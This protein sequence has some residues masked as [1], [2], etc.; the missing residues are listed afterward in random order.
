MT[1]ICHIDCE[2]KSGVDITN[3]VD[4]YVRDPDYG[5]LIGTYAFDDGPVRIWEPWDGEPI[6]ADL[7]EAARDPA[8]LFS[9]HNARFERLTIN[10]ELSIPL[11]R[12]RCTMA[13]AYSHALPGAL[14]SLCR[15]LGLDDDK[16]KK[17]DGK[18][19]I[20][21][22]CTP[23]FADPREHPAD[24][25]DFLDYAAQDV[26]AMRECRRRMPNVNY[27]K[28]QSELEA[29][30]L[31]QRINDRGF[32]VDV[33]MAKVAMCRLAVEKETLN[34][35]ISDVSGGLITKGTQGERIKDYLNMI[36]GIAVPDMQK[37]TLE[38]LLDSG[39]VTGDA[40]TLLNIRRDLSR[41]STSKYER[42][43]NSQV[44]G[45]IH[46]AAQFCGAGRTGRW[47]GRIFQPLNLPRP[48]LKAD[49]VLAEVEAL[50]RN[51]PP[52]LYGSEHDRCADGLRSAIVAGPG[53]KLVVADWSS[54][55][56][57]LNAWL[58]K[59]QWVLD[60][61]AAGR[62]MYIETYKKSFGI[63]EDF[64][65]SDPRRQKGKCMD[66]AYGYEGGA[67]ASVT[68]AKT[69]GLDL[70]EWS[71]GALEVASPKVYEGAEWMWDWAVDNGQTHGLDKQI[72]LGL[73]CS[74]IAWRDSRPQTVQMWR[75]LRDAMF[76]ALKSHGQ[77][78]RVARCQ[79]MCTGSVLALK[80]PTG[81][82]LLYANPRIS[83]VKQLNDDG[84]PAEGADAKTRTAVTC[85]SPHGGRQVLYGG[86]VDE[87][88][89]QALGR[90]ILVGSMPRVEAAGYEIVLHVYDEI[91]AE[92]PED[93]PLD[94][95]H[96]EKLICE[97]HKWGPDIPLAAEG[98]TTRR[99]KKD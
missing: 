26:E 74:K 11:E 80:L 84:E 64:A 66:L 79:M 43:V 54:I 29:W 46:G 94:H 71:E 60:A 87:N 85:M 67:G 42:L 68:A 24:W 32:A 97:P 75:D 16:A 52:M 58:A 56:G 34:K 25:V 13:Q 31:D 20:R 3:G 41:S 36:C 88:I 83:R 95:K 98:F 1:T 48:K 99:Y 82:M 53:K 15:I 62:D 19:L 22:F 81:R 37:D 73:Q 86:K 7:V 90:E 5:L 92:V 12:W 77:V 49:A 23:E 45:R 9:A 51:E 8:V 38:R 30:F 55:E 28:L 6:P 59:E 35:V 2:T 63:T 40:L 78:F 70:E 76:A 10:Q 65:K 93:S 4:A 18:A 21:K 91:A 17:A 47:A 72:F 33:Q 57:R 89:C 69:Y 61:Y 14:D 96:L 39:D 44:D 50:K 27:P